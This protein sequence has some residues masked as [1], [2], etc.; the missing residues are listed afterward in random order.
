MILKQSQS[1]SHNNSNNQPHIGKRALRRKE[2]LSIH[3][4]G[5]LLM[6][7]SCGW[8]LPG[9]TRK[10]CYWKPLPAGLI[11]M[12]APRQRGREKGR[13][14]SRVHRDLGVCH[15]GWLFPSSLRMHEAGDRFVLF[16]TPILEHTS[17]TDDLVHSLSTCKSSYSGHLDHSHLNQ[18]RMGGGR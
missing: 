18:C 7:L 9:A 6:W 13:A 3:R 10:L 11:A 12:T 17:Q 4:R 8:N 1:S 14:K 5:G 15:H 2:A 16:C